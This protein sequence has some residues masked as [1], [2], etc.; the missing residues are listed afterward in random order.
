MMS[1]ESMPCDDYETSRN[2]WLYRM[3]LER[4]LPK[5]HRVGGLAN[6]EGM[7]VRIRTLRGSGAIAELHR[8][9]FGS[10]HDGKL[11]AAYLS[12]PCDAAKRAIKRFFFD[13]IRPK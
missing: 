1:C 7:T 12:I 2:M 6:K 5:K 8:M 4:D 11:V 3:G 13:W 9:Q 10:D